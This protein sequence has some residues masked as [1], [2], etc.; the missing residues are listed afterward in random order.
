MS[1]KYVEI[2]EYSNYGVS[3]CGG[4]K[5]LK[6]GRVL[7]PYQE[8]SGYLQVQLSKGDGVFKGFRIHRLVATVFIDNPHN[9]E[10]VN[11]IDGDKSNNF[12]DNL[13]WCSALHNVRHAIEAGLNNNRGERNGNA[14]LTF[15]QVNEIRSLRGTGTHAEISKKTRVGRTTV[16][17]ILNGTRWGGV[18]A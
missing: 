2:P 18:H 3:P 15:E 8:P 4:V 14:S 11:H 1:K 10:M 17:R 12:K 5:N 7:K 9:L 6:T 13:E 16:T